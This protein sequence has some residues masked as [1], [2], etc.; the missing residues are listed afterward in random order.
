[1]EAILYIECDIPA[2]LTLAEYRRLNP[3]PVSRWR[4]VYR[5][6]TSRL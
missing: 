6:L 1:M 2:G 5:A 4:R 3:R